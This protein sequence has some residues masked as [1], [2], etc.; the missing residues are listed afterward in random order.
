MIVKCFGENER[1]KLT[2][3]PGAFLGARTRRSNFSNNKNFG[4]EIGY[5]QAQIY[6]IFLYK[7]NWTN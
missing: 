2:Q 4:T 5:I 6:V 1:K 3:K 7:K